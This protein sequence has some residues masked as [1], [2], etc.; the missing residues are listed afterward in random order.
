MEN[1]TI[2]IRT[3][4][5]VHQFEIG[6]FLHEDGESCKIRIFLEGRFV[7]NFRPDAHGY[8]HVCQNPGK[9]EERLLY[10]LAE[11]IE[12]HHP[13]GINKDLAER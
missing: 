10:L 2:D 1:Y 11:E 3:G 12:A 6:E 4:K 13:Q 5:K 9:I 8:L 7:A